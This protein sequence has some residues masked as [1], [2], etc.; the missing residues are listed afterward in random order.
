MHMLYICVYISSLSSLDD[1]HMIFNNRGLRCKRGYQYEKQLAW[2][3]DIH[4][5]DTGIDQEEEVVPAWPKI[6]Q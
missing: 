5:E 3:F 6:G 4:M 2:M 1:S